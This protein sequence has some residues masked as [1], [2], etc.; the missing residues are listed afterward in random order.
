MNCLRTLVIVWAVVCLP[1]VAYSQH[2]HLMGIVK[3]AQTDEPVPAASLLFKHSTIGL[4]SDSSGR[5]S[6]ELDHW[7]S[8]S[9]EVSSVGYINLSLPI[10]TSRDTISIEILLSE[11]KQMDSIYIVRKNRN[12]RGL[13]LWRRILMNRRFNDLSQLKNYSFEQYDKT[14]IDLRNIKLDHINIFSPLWL[15]KKEI[16]QLKAQLKQG[17]DTI[18]GSRYMPVYLSETLSDQY[19]QNH[20][21]RRAGRLRAKNFNGIDNRTFHNILLQ[22]TESFDVYDNTITIITRDFI[23]PFG[24]AGNEY[25]RY[26]LTDTQ[27]IDNKRYFHLLFIP[28]IKGTNTVK[29]ESWIQ[30]S[31]YAIQ[32]VHF[33]LNKTANINFLDSLAYTREFSRS[34]NQWFPKKERI[35]AEFSALNRQLPGFIIRK[36]SSFSQSR[37]ND[38]S[39]S[40]MISSLPAEAGSTDP[41]LPGSQDWSALRHEP[42]DQREQLI[43][44][45][46]DSL[47]KNNAYEKLRVK[48]KFIATGYLKAGPIDIGPWFYWVSGNN[49]EGLRLRMDVRTNT[50]FHKKLW[51]HGYLAFGNKDQQLKGKI[52]SMYILNRYP[53]SQL[54]ASFSNDL[55]FDQSY[56]SSFS[57]NNLFSGMLR[58]SG[59]P[60]KFMRKKETRLEYFQESRVGLSG[61]FFIIEKA[62]NPLQNLPGKTIFASGTD[63]DPFSTLEAGIR[64]RFAYA[65]KFLENDFFRTSQGSR[66]PVIEMG[67]SKGFAGVLNG[68][69][70]YTKLTAHISQVL[71]LAAIGRMDMNLF[72][73][74]TIGTLPYVF[75]DPHPGNEL[76]Y[77]NRNAFNMMNRYEFISD[78]FIS[79]NIEHQLGTGIFQLI[80][81]LKWR[82]FWNAKFLAG[83][84]SPSNRALNLASDHG[85][86]TLDNKAYLELGTGIDNIFNLFRL[87]LVWNVS[88]Q[89][90]VSSNKRFGIF[91]STR[92]SF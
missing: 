20:P 90:L 26:Y 66:Y 2:K 44:N 25:Y 91:G 83:D 53:R 7:P 3:D 59:V 50:S 47:G 35:F 54:R 68:N 12:D 43:I 49:Y 24:I 70:N 64:L 15:L 72:G 38:T 29:G 67:I 1:G 41:V 27:L 80:P 60:L 84:L 92:I 75:L 22:L 71:Q 56:Y 58:K 86:K 16:Y 37:Y 21:Y 89:S 17:I 33:Q 62:Y 51:F 19:F 77:F 61:T 5:F 63:K 74:R 23:S 28:K 8:D 52:E 82:Q 48:L 45:L 87:D 79:F 46:S 76:H 88:H 10:D 36:T 30:D 81:G 57:S 65:E 73:A 78:R 55:D 11:R 6:V 42:L 85:F 69:N 40:R 9:L 4:L 39:I 13:Q 34:G 31:S 32:K 18:S 14:E